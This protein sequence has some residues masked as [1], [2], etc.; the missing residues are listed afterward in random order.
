MSVDAM[1]DELAALDCGWM[2]ERGAKDGIVL[3]VEPH[4]A[5][6]PALARVEGDDV[7][8]VARQVL[9]LLAAAYADNWCRDLEPADQ[10][11][12]IPIELLRAALSDARV[13]RILP[14]R[15]PASDAMPVSVADRSSGCGG[16]G[17]G[18]TA[19]D[20]SSRFLHL[21]SKSANR[22]PAADIAPGC[23][24]GPRAARTE[25]GR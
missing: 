24:I 22:T 6:A 5:Q 9:D 17:H 16:S 14:A 2:I 10:P 3:T 11:Q 25:G 15:G 12:L 1:F 7:A 20:G 21:E 4:P 8:H 18:R 13:S 19:I 23:N